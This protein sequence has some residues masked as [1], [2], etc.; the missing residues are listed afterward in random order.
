MND[1]HEEESFVER[2]ARQRLHSVQKEK[3]KPYIQKKKRDPHRINW[4]QIILQIMMVIVLI[5]MI[6]S[7]L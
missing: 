4:T 2:H 7:M 3:R 6:L 1:H 5:S